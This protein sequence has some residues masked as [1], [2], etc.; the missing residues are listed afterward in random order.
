MSHLNA[1]VIGTGGVGSAAAF[2]LAERGAKVL[3]LDRFGAAHDR[4]SS[5]GQT[6]IIRQAYFEHPDYVPMAVRSYELWNQLAERAG[7]KLYHEVGLVQIGP[8]DGVVVPGVLEA[9]RAHNLPVEHL[10]ADEVHA[11]WP[12]FRVREGYAAAFER[13]AGYLRVED[14]IRAH[15]DAARDCSAELRTGIEVRRWS[16]DGHGVRVETDAGTFT[17]DRLIITAGAWAGQLLADLGIRLEVRRKPLYWYACDDTRYEAAAGCPGFLFEL[18]EGVFYGF[19]KID[20]LGVKV[21]EH[22]GGPVVDDP[23][24]LDREVDLD[25]R[26]R[27]ETFLAAHLP[28]VSLQMTN[29]S[30]CMYTMT[31]D[32][33]FIVDRHPEHP[34]VV[35][36]AGLSGHGFKF[37]STLGQ[38]LA[39]LTLAG[40]TDL[41][42]GFLSLDRPGLLDD[43][44]H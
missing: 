7:Q 29:H 36:A 33:H 40:H 6:R 22:S 16:A 26:Q 38:S 13:R 2:H 31:P 8:P 21:A 27:V 15:L 3:G 24:T 23:L 18:P 39:D 28:G 19:S 41:P 20:A 25:D 44:S 17:A 11:Q 43:P 12:G 42:I 35:F 14:C 5:H 37:A 32:E 30:V 9:A 1:I 34:N 10:S 4:G